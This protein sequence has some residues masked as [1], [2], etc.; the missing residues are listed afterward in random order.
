MPAH[1]TN[2]DALIRRED[3]EVQADASQ[4]PSQVA[5]TLSV[6][7]L[8]EGSLWFQVLRKPDF[9]RETAN[10]EPDKIADLI[11]SFLNGDLIPSIIL[12]R[13][14][15]SGNIFVIDGAHRLSAFMAW[16]LNDYGDEKISRPFFANFIPEEQIKVA[17]KTRQMI[18][19][20]VGSYAEL[21]VALQHPENATPDRLRLAKNLGAFALSLQWVG[22]DAAKAEQSFFKINQKATLIDPTELEMINARHKA[23]ALTTRALIRAGTGHKYWSAFQ[24]STQQE[25]EKIAREVYDVLF[26]PAIETPIKTLDLP[27]AGRG[28]SADSVKMVFDLVNFVNHVPTK[29]GL[30]DDSDGTET[31]KYL[32]AVRRSAL[33]IAGT[34]PESLGL[35]PVVY[36]YGATGK[37]QSSAF[38]AAV[39][40]VDE[41][42]R[43]KAFVKFTGA[44]QRFEEFLLR[45]RHFI[46]QVGRNYGAGQRGVKAILMMYDGVLSGVVDGK[47]D[48]AIIEELRGQPA[49]RFL[50]EITLEDKKHGKNFSRETKSAAYLR[51]AMGKELRCKICEA[52]LHFKS[53]SIDHRVRREGGGSGTEDNAQ[54][55]HP[56]C[57]TGY[58]ESGLPRR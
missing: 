46:N 48:D 29:G 31:L 16:V 35:H 7:A 58:K 43:R 40:F 32:R 26:R 4:T 53:I 10:W 33:R 19:D 28:Y 42:E 50:A 36:F 45:Y 15:I 41:L 56:Y 13:S 34:A 14:P 37:F 9:Q 11:Q 25:I 2:L 17:E 27:V 20:R 52:R 21:K 18:K 44:R 3:F 6:M 22:G 49:L 51:E 39:A 8:E 55:T 23:N 30:P 5:N 57:N 38:L 12:W 24:Q 54:L 1:F 47:S